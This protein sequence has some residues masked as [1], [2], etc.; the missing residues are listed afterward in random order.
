MT[1]ETLDATVGVDYR[2][3]VPGNGVHGTDFLT[4]AT[5]D[6]GRPFQLRTK[7]NPPVGKP[8]QWGGNETH[9]PG[10]PAEPRCGQFLPVRPPQIHLIKGSRPQ[11]PLR[12]SPEK[13]DVEGV[14]VPH[15]NRRYQIDARG[16]RPCKNPSHPLRGT[17]G[18]AIALHA[19]T[20]SNTWNI[21]RARVKRSR[22]PW[23]R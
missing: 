10:G 15:G 2:A 19:T 23:T 17:V 16:I 22:I 3:V 5:P 4:D 18:G 13:R 14:R 12:G 9:K 1:T 6:A 21:G 11:P 8:P 20:A 7:G